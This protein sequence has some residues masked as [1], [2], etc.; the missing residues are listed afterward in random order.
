MQKNLEFLEAARLLAA[1]Y[2]KSY[3]TGFAITYPGELPQ[4]SAQVFSAGTRLEDGALVTSGGRVVGV[5]AT[6]DTLPQAVARAYKAV[7]RVHFSNAYYRRD[8]GARALTAM[9]G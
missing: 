5:T 7:E 1:G 4:L 9:E 3:E 2:P 8:I 6:A